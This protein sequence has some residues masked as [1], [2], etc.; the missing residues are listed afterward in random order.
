[1]SPTNFQK[2]VKELRTVTKNNKNLHVNANNYDA[3]LKYGNSTYVRFSS[4]GGKVW[5]WKGQTA[6]N[7][8]QKGLGTR[9]RK[10]GVNAAVL[11]GVP[12][13]HEG[14][15]VNNLVSQRGVPISTRI[16]YKLG[17]VPTGARNLRFK[18]KKY[19]F[20][21][22]VPAHGKGTRSMTRKR[23]SVLNLNKAS[24]NVNR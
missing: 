19:S 5:L 3:Q 13:Y 23:R 14:I 9:L 22:V 2:F 6:R 24:R 8:R 7:Q 16:M 4:Q 11:A 17:A 12:L 20:L 21:S 1:M 15:N 18:T 10:Y